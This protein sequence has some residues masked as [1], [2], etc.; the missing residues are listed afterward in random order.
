LVLFFAAWYAPG[1]FGGQVY[2]AEDIANYFLANRGALY[3]LAHGGAFSWWDP[4]PGLG[5]PRLGNIQTGYLT[6]LSS[7]FYAL[8]PTEAFRFYPPLALGVLAL[9]CFALFRAKG[10]GPIPALFGALAFSTLGNVATHVQQP[11]VLDTLV[12]LPATLLA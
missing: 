12:W 1:V 2:Y 5:M 7:L 9:F 3:D 6:P 10:V 4:L 11:P 8:P